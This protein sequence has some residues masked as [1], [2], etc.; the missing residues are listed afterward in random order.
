MV[1]HRGICIAALLPVVWV[2]AAVAATTVA[3]LSTMTRQYHHRYDMI[4]A[5]LLAVSA[6]DIESGK[7]SKV[8]TIKA[9]DSA[10]LWN[11]GTDI[12]PVSSPGT[13][14]LRSSWGSRPRRHSISATRPISFGTMG[15][16]I[17]IVTRGIL[18]Y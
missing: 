15:F 12:T 7:V 5:Q 14:N 1:I 8:P 2:I 6:C 10:T 17:I 11:L 9:F 18:G 16:T 13:M 3:I 4:Q